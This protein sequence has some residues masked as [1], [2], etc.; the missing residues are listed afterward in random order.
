MSSQT[1]LSVDRASHGLERFAFGK[2]W[3]RFLLSL[4]DDRICEAEK[5]LLEML[6]AENLHQKSFLDVGCG[7]GLFSL[8]AMR[9]GAARVHSFDFDP[10][11]VACAHELKHRYFQHDGHWTIQRGSVLD[12]EFLA[13]LGRFDIV[14]SW[15]VLHHT[16]DL[17]KALENTVPLVENRGCLYIALYNDQGLLSVAWKQIKLRYNRSLLWRALIIPT[18]ACGIAAAFFAKDLMF[19]HRNPITRYREYRKSRGMA[20]TTDLLDWLGG[21]PF[22]VARPDTVFDFFRERGFELAKL[23]TVGMGLGNNEFVFIKR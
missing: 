8:A 20:Y 6:A 2:N 23:K 9:L 17:W 7:S 3:Q 13:S 11:S 10:H 1:L 5:S 15:G 16:G 18:F 19:L 21:Y 22:E 4:T 12:S 14:Y